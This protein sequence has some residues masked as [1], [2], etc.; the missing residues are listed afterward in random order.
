MPEWAKRPATANSIN[1]V[2]MLKLHLFIDRV[3]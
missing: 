3:F 2:R 1:S